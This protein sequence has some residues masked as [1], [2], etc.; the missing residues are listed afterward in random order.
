M[1]PNRNTLIITGSEDVEGQRTMLNLTREALKEPRPMSP[2]P[3]ILKDGEWLNYFPQHDTPLFDDYAT[4]RVETF[5]QDYAEQKALLE[6]L[7]EKRGEDIFVASFSSMEDKETKKIESFCV[8]SR[9]VLTLLPK[10]DLIIFYDH[11]KPEKERKVCTARWADVQRTVGALMQ[12]QGFYPERYKVE[13]FPN[14]P[15]ITGDAFINGCM[16]SKK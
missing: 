10:T 13:S 4:F 8:W 6:K 14:P 5:G 3:L 16:T 2:R 11:E 15:S 1:A 9:D 12:P 7:Y